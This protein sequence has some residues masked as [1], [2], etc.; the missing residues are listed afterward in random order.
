[1]KVIAEIPKGDKVL[2]EMTTTEMANILGAYSGHSLQVTV[3]KEYKASYIYNKHSSIVNV[4]NEADYNTAR[5]KLRAMLNALTPI[6]DLL[7][8]LPTNEE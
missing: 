4:Q 8:K 5:A 7:N 1:M 6:E 2:V 3:G